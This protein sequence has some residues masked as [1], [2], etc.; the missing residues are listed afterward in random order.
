M[1]L[2]GTQCHRKWR[3]VIGCYDLLLSAVTLSLRCTIFEIL[4]L[5]QCSWL[6]VTLRSP[7]VSMRQLKNYI[8]IGALRQ[9]T[10]DFQ[11]VLHWNCLYLVPLLIIVI[12][13]HRPIYQNFMRSL[14]HDYTPFVGNL[15]CRCLY[16]PWTIRIPNLRCLASPFRRYDAAKKNKNG[17]LDND[18][19]RPFVIPR[20]ILSMAYMCTK[21][22]D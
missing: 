14:V 11:S 18:L 1:T 22:E 16:S 19:V 10:Y 3:D 4:P 15:S 21:C 17:S 2:L 20:L 9:A 5:L 6:P 12:Y 7:P 13:Y 8:G